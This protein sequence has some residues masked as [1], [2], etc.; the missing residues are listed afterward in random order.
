[1]GQSKKGGGGVKGLASD[2]MEG[3][4]VWCRGYGFESSEKEGRKWS[5]E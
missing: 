1:M 5:V 3:L 4:V 2:E